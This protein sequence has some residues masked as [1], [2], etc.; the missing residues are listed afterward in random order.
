MIALSRKPELDL[1]ADAQ[2]IKSRM[3]EALGKRSDYDILVGRGN[4]ISTIKQ[5][6]DLA[7]KILQG[8]G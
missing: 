4:S 3:A 1:E 6:V 7:S 2:G 5:R 8:E